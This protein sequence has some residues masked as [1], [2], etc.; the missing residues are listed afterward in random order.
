MREKEG[1]YVNHKLFL[2]CCISEN[3]IPNGLRLEL[4]P[5]IG[6]HDETFLSNWYEKLQQHSQGF[7]KD[8]ITFCH[9]IIT[10]LKVGIEKTEKKSEKH[11][12][13][14]HI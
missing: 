3:I 4:E 2:A 6:N 7:M 11:S 12:R 13:E 8:I 9:K 1:G 10:K 14:Q 5:T